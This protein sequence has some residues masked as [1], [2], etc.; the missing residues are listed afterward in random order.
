M[1]SNAPAVSPVVINLTGTYG[2]LALARYRELTRQLA[3]TTRVDEKSHVPSGSGEPPAK[4]AADAACSDDQRS[5]ELLSLIGRSYSK[6]A[7]PDAPPPHSQCPA[8]KASSTLR[9]IDFAWSRWSDSW[10]AVAALL[11]S[12]ALT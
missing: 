10:R 5:H 11:G 8:R 1:T 9:N 4:V 12:T 2:F 7:C 6:T 3:G